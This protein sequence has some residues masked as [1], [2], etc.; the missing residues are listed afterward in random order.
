LKPFL[1]LRSTT[2]QDIL[3]NANA[4]WNTILT[5]RDKKTKLPISLVGATITMK[6]RKISTSDPW[7]FNLS[8]GNGLEIIGT[9]NNKISITGV[10][11]AACRYAY[12]LNIT[13]A[14]QEVYII[15]GT[16]VAE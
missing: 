1:D 16:L 2:T 10:Q 12:E 3:I 11:L 4:P 8:V 6:G 7:A 13:T 5:M 14:V 15:K 9:D